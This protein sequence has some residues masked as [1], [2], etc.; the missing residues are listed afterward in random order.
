MAVPPKMRIKIGAG[1]DGRVGIVDF[2]ESGSGRGVLVA[3]V[4]G[5]VEEEEEGCS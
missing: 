4:G 3:N 2:A 5:A 1:E